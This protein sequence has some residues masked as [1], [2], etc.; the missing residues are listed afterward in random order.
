MSNSKRRK[1]GRP[2]TGKT[3]GRRLNLYVTEPREIL[4]ERAF[5]LLQNHDMLP[6]TAELRTSRTEIIDYALDALIKK[7][8][9]KT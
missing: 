6:T 5:E 4:F 2:P 7:L 9:E 3:R 1:P 8:E